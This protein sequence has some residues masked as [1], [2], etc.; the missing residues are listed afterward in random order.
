MGRAA[1]RKLE[2]DAEIIKKIN[3][4]LRFPENRWIVKAFPSFPTRKAALRYIEANFRD[5]YVTCDRLFF[6]YFL[7]SSKSLNPGQ[8]S[9]VAS[10]RFWGGVNDYTF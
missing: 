4:Y 9:R 5:D 10:D 1:K 3:Y 2:K 8:I 7:L 6:R